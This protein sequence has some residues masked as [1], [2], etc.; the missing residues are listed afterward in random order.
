LVISRKINL[1]LAIR[2]R[3]DRRWLVCPAHELAFVS[4]S[5][6]RRVRVDRVKGWVIPSLAECSVCAVRTIKSV[7]EGVSEPTVWEEAICIW[8]IVLKS[9]LI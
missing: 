4:T 8:W 9:G 7:E 2:D 5:E 3:D 6:V 1:L